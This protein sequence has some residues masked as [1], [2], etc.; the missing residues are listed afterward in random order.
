ML[1]YRHAFHAGNH[2]DV[3]KHVVLVA[4]LRHLNQKDKPY[5]VI[6]THAGAGGYAL[7]SK[8][9]TQHDEFQ[10]GIGKLW[11]VER[12][13]PPL[14][15]DY[16]GVVRAFNADDGRLRRYPGS[17][18]IVRALIR[19]DDR[20]RLF[21]LHPT[22]FEILLANFSADRRAKVENVDGFATIKAL[23]PP[24]PR[25]ALVFIDP[26]YEI[27]TDYAKVHAAVQDGLKRFA[28]GMFMVWIP[29]LTRSEPAQLI[30]RL[31]RL[32]ADDWLHVKLQVAE[33]ADGGFGM[34]GTSMFVINPPWTLREQ[35]AATMPFL[36]ET[37]GQVSGAGYLIEHP[38]QARPAT[39]RPRHTAP[40]R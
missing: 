10:D 9:A 23:L 17:P 21:E 32:P 29:M 3:L 25:R 28:Q 5:W 11:S 37:L 14:V 13:L 12:K 39:P 40:R 20:Q 38:G 33:P 18:E 8:Y 30:D 1:A 36:V 22:D 35:L 6:D 26:S 16:L 34:L 15:D 7:D 4:A 27:K 2:A 19:A 24:P 31:K